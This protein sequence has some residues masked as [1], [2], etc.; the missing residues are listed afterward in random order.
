MSRW[1][2][3]ILFG[4]VDAMYASSAIVADPSLAGK[5]V[6][7]GSPPPRGI[8][9]AASYP[10]RRYG[11]RAAMPTARALRLCPDLILVPPDRALYRRMHARMRDV[12]DALFPATE[13]TSI[14]EFYADTTDL[15][16]LYP[17]PD[18]LGRKVKDAI[19]DATGLRC[20]IGVA[21]GKVI[22]KIAAD[23]HKPD[24]LGVIAPGTEAAFLGPRPVAALPGVGAK[25]AEALASR[26][27]RTIADLL[28]PR[29]EPSLRRLWGSRLASLQALA[30]G[31]DDD[32]VVPDREAKSVSHE[33][34]FDEDTADL[35]FLE[36][37]LH[38]F[39]GALAHDLRLEGLAAGSFTVKLKDAGFHITTRQR[40]FPK[41][42]N[43][44]PPMWLAIR[45]ALEGLVE[46]RTKYRLAGLALGDLVPAVNTLFD[47]RT[48]KAL[49]AMDEIIAKHGT[50]VMRL[51][52]LPEE[53]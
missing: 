26:G 40:H 38:G 4:D 43:F 5:L 53:E 37:T 13:W 52:A 27:V 30:R 1:R 39:L 49:A 7:V 42:L 15:Q 23:A 16:S 29:V 20:T 25:T 17:D 12:T 10:V 44:D 50:G 21:S 51:G 48:T 14:D 35:A 3:Q 32:P 36:R 2:R 19:F 46:P 41:P 18:A 31:I 33:T 47:G 6:A 9:T 24:G 45:P 34:T 28:D 22:A 11:V 8:I